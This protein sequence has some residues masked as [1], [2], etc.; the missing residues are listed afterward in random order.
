VNI[1][2]F[3][4][5]LVPIALTGETTKNAVIAG[6]VFVCLFFVCLFVCLFVLCVL[7]VPS[8]IKTGNGS[9]YYSQAFEM[10]CR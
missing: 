2:N 8:Q 9:G 1:D 5:F 7:S 6:A 4:G 10:F 3:L